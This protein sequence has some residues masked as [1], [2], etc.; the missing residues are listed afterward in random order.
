MEKRIDYTFKALSVCGM[1]FVLAG[2]FGSHAF[3]F[4]HLYKYDLFHM[5]LFLFISGYFFRSE[6]TQTLANTFGF[7]KRKFLRLMVPYFI[8]NLVYFGIML[9]LQKN[10]VFPFSVFQGEVSWRNFVLEPFQ[11]GSGFGYNVAAWFVPFL[12]LVE[13]VYCVIRWCYEKVFQKREFPLILLFFLLAWMGIKLSRME[14]ESPWR[15]G[16]TR[17]MYG[18][19]WYAFAVFYRRKLETI[20]QKIPALPALVGNAL[21]MALLAFRFGNTN[22]VIYTASFPTQAWITFLRAG[23]GIW[24][25]LRIC[26]LLAPIV[27]RSKAILFFADHTFSLMMHQGLAGLILNALIYMSGI[28]PDFDIERF[29][30][31]IWFG[32]GPS[33][34]RIIYVILIPIMIL[35]PVWFIEKHVKN[36]FIKCLF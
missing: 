34:F 33:E 15:I 20:D 12:F 7:I 9:V 21:L 4:A 35:L 24:F 6:S 10:S 26:R 19:F 8:W 2:H 32:V 18:T 27:A 30:S 22:P 36:R 23:M 28:M 5:P 31:S 16:V 3:C 17:V 29:R 14:W 1:L 13:S 25:W 11:R